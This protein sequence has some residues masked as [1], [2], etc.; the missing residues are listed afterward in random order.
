MLNQLFQNIQANKLQK[1]RKTL[2]TFKIWAKI[3]KILINRMTKNLHKSL[4]ILNK[5][6]KNKQLLN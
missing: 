4:K 2:K 3:L 5:K 1:S 6:M